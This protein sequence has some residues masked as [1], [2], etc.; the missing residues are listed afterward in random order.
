MEQIVPREKWLYNDR[1][2]MKWMGWLLSDHSAFM[3]NAKG[4]EQTHLVKS[5]MSWT[6]I[7]SN[8]KIAWEKS[9]M[10]VVQ[11]NMI[12]NSA[13][14]PEIKGMVIGFNAGQIYLLLDNGDTRL[15]HVE[16]IRYVELVNNI[17]WYNDDNAI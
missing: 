7:N 12:E 16:D 11:L 1:G 2:M 10:V 6:E 3:E 17:K 13:Y 15:I 5:E 9:E 8:L 14:I 4:K